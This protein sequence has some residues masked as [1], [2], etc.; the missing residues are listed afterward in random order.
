MHKDAEAFRS[1]VTIKGLRTSFWS[2][3]FSTGSPDREL[4]TDLAGVNGPGE[5]A[6]ASPVPAA[7]QPDGATRVSVTQR[8]PSSWP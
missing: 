8:E 3:S 5:N 4:T 6:D 1:T 2:C 7:T